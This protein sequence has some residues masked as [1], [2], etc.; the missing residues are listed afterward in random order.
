[1]KNLKM[2]LLENSISFFMES[3]EKAIQAENDSDKWKFAIL[4]LVQAIETSLKERLRK[5]H[6]L[7]VYS[8]IDNPIHTV[9]LGLSIK[10]LEN[11]SGVKLESSDRKCIETASTLRNQIVHFEFDLSVDQIKSNFVSLVGFYTAFCRN[12]L[13]SDI[14]SILPEELHRELLSLD[15]Y[16]EE[17]EKRALERIISESLDADDIRGCPA[18]YKETFVTRDGKNICYL[19]NHQESVHKC[20]YC[21]VIELHRDMEIVDMGNMKGLEHY[22]MICPSCYQEMTDQY[23]YDYHYE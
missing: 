6:E 16:V 18:C 21:D 13:E 23:A 2:T 19:C 10:R 1:M 9:N 8:N 17:L 20:E 15:S 14:V 5:T 4:L 11:I 7:F 3:I 12:E 22:V